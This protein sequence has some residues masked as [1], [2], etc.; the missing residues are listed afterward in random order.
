MLRMTAV[1]L[2]LGGAGLSIAQEEQTHTFSFGGHVRA[3]FD[4]RD[5]VNSTDESRFEFESLKLTV[6]GQSG[7]FS[8]KADYR[9]YENV[10]MDVVKYADATYTFN[11]NQSL[12][13]GIT[14][15]PFG[16]LPY[17]SNS[18]WFS[19]NYYLGLEDDYDAGFVYQHKYRDWQFHAGYFFNDEYNKPGEF[20]R[21][22][23]DVA[24][25]GERR[26]KENGQYNLRF[27][28]GFSWQEGI[29]T[30]VGASYQYGDILN[31]DTN[32]EGEHTAWAVHMRSNY[33]PVKLELEYIDYA[34]DLAVPEGQSD[35]TVVLSAFT[36]PFPIASEGNSMIANLVYSVPYENGVIKNISC[37]TEY[38]LVDSNLAIGSESVQWANG[39]SF[40]LEQLSI[41][42]DSIQGKNMWFS[43]GSGVA[44]DFPDSDEW[45]HRL[46]IN[47]G[48]YF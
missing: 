16:L 27:S 11:Q 37:Y 26:N 43:G 36:F 8:Y 4:H 6:Q 12:R 39:C 41:Y 47:F 38:G 21:Y 1:V 19:V 45:T 34:Y 35:D 25:D 18:F 42:I 28:R 24:D 20:G 15:V 5:W 44:V 33:G 32:E 10:D 3:N 9:M 30:D 2:L 31:L 17:A 40:S 13:G 23:F 46:N 22:S 14:Q 48:Y 7:K 29:T